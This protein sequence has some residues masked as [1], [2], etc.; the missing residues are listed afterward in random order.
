MGL[1]V[2]ELFVC[3]SAVMMIVRC[4]GEDDDVESFVS[5]FHLLDPIKPPGHFAIP[6]HMQSSRPLPC[7]ALDSKSGTNFGCHTPP[8][9]VR[10]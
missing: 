10:F 7:I 9:G 5:G 4:D 2:R 6:G 3:E 1:M 8:V